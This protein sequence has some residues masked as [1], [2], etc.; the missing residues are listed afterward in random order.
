LGSNSFLQAK[1][2]LSFYGLPVTREILI[3]QRDE[4]GKAAQQIGYPLVIKGCSFE[5][6]HK[7]EKGLI[8]T[9][10]RNEVEAL[11]AFDKI[12]KQLEGYNSGILLQEMVEGRRELVMGLMRD[13]QF[14][15]CVMFGLGGIFT[16]VLK[17]IT[18][19]KVP[20]DES[21]A[22]EMMRELKGNKI[23]DAFRGMEAIDIKTLARMLI[24]IGRI[25]QEFECVREIDLNPVIICRGKPIV[26]D[27]LM[28]LG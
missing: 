26:V 6:A 7:T 2:V 12:S 18:F 23:I 28:I 1:Q 17:D 4:V 9:D 11:D 14:G 3:E 20:F 22:L 16:E 15:P 27:A 19:R 13:D 25:G 5:I 8:H 21:D 24:G 10:I